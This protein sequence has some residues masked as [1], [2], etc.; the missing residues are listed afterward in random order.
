MNQI[1]ASARD[2]GTASAHPERVRT[3]LIRAGMPRWRSM[4]QIA[5]SA[6][7]CGTAS[8]HP[9]T[10]IAGSMTIASGDASGSAALAAMTVPVRERRVKTLFAILE[11]MDLVLRIG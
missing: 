7:D 10:S 3:D 5:A 4:N 11:E 6:R 1:A 8:A 2:C 9:E